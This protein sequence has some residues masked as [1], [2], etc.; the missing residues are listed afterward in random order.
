MQHYITLKNNTRVAT[1]L[2]KDNT[3]TEARHKEDQT[4]LGFAAYFNNVKV[5]KL[6]VECNADMKQLYILLYHATT[7]NWHKWF[8]IIKHRSKQKIKIKRQ[9]STLLLNTAKRQSHSC[10]SSINQNVSKGQRRE[11]CSSVGTS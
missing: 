9:L 6:L 8:L 5:V 1:L 4:P 10:C 7:K 11:S 2:F 3:D